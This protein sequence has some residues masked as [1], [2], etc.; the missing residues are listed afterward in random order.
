MYILK[1]A[2]ISISRNKGRNI[3]IA[4]LIFVIA[5]A[6]T[7]TLAIRNAASRLIDSYGDSEYVNNYFY[8]ATT[9]LNSSQIEAVTS[10]FEGG[11]KEGKGGPVRSDQQNSTG[12]FTI[13]G[14]NS[15]TAMSEFIT[16]D[17]T[18]T[19]G[20][21]SA[22][23]SSNSCLVNEELATTNH[24]EVGDT[25]TFT[26]PS[27]SSKT[28]T[29]EI[30]GIYT[31]NEDSSDNKM[32]MFSNSS[33]KI[34]T[35]INQVLKMDRN[36]TLSPTYILKSMDV[37]NA[38]K[39]EVS[40]KGLNEYL[41]VQDNLSEVENQLS[42]ISNVKTF[43]TTFLGITLLIGGIVLFVINMIHI[44]ERK[45]EIGVLRTIGMTK[46]KLSMQ[47]IAEVL[48]VAF[49]AL[50]AG[51]CVGSVVSVPVA[52]H[53]LESEINTSRE[54]KENIDRNFGKNDSIPSKEE[55]ETNDI[56]TQEPAEEFDSTSLGG[57]NVEQIT[58]INAVV[59]FK[60]IV[61]LLL[62]GLGLTFI[63]SCASMVSI[64][65]FSPLTILKERS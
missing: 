8:I 60:V 45:Y 49:F 25:I 35:N 33:N 19:D 21:V 51:A 30:S 14:Y 13:V 52:N 54:N 61:Q 50:V 15:Y 1:N 48:I 55:T 17:Y 28:Y 3:L 41:E 63:S 31:D 44:R 5:I 65:R 39:E 36:A 4:I 59:D 2:W 12:D 7:V 40:S 58:Q 38:F 27:D 22:D 42:S 26:D 57:L 10:T 62:I 64:Q 37:L 18:I 47:F 16:G 34:I 24:L 9:Y 6:S 56:K 20:S 46:S 29:L 32:N 43:A 53:L 11:N 23:F